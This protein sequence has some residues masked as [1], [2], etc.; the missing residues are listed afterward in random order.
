VEDFYSKH[1]GEIYER[2]TVKGV[3]RNP[4][5]QF[6]CSCE[7][8]GSVTCDVFS[9]LHKK[10]RS[11]GCLKKELIRERVLGVLRP[12]VELGEVFKNKKNLEFEIIQYEASTKV[13]VRFTLSGFEA[14]SAVKEIKNGSIRD[15]VATPLLPKAMYTRT[16]ERGPITRMK[17][18]DVYSNSY[19]S[20]YEV[21]QLLPNSECRVKFLD[22]FGYEKVALRNDVK[23]GI[24]NP[25]HR[26]MFSLGYVGEGDY[27]PDKDRRVFTLWGNMFRRCYDPESWLK[28][29]TYMDCEVGNDWC[30]F[31]DFAK[32]C[33]NQPEFTSQADWCL[34][35]D[36]LVKGNK[37]YSAT[38]CAF[39]PRDINNLFTLRGNKRGDY[40]LGVHKE[41]KSGKFIAQ[42]NREG[43][44]I[45]LG[46][47]ATPEQAFLVYKEAKESVVKEIAEK[48][49]SEINSNVYTSLIN[50]KVEVTD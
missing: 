47:F 35:K 41:G 33:Y 38:T 31:Q 43:R 30:C 49:K 29:P 26:N 44:R 34:D 46:R 9:I 4:R 1:I 10:T 6:L 7:C 18:G 42:I 12:A 32:W 2:L 24:R 39:V 20:K 45:C 40:P 23:K 5:P 50:W 14:W 8:G 16:T 21:V 27:T 37:I 48:Y 17:L 36:I 11:C 15:W 3:V 13:K 22:E 25:F 19:G 28:L